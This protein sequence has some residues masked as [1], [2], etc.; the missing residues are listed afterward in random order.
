[1]GKIDLGA[2]FNKGW[3]AFS[4]NMVSMIVGTLIAVLITGVSAG[5]LATVMFGGLYGMARKS[6]RGETAEIGDVFAGF[7]NFGNLFLAGLLSGVVMVA[8]M[9]LCCVG[10][11]FTA[12]LILFMIPLVVDGNGVGEA[13]GKSWE[14]YKANFGGFFLASLVLSLV[15]GAGN[16]VFVGGLFTV[17][18]AICVTW[19]A[20]EQVFGA[21]E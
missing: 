20:Y 12:P 3:E 5:L 1:M 7:S 11:F 4:K 21:T 2:A 8:G 10:I 14:A 15:M 16:A 18:F 19:A 9:L 13:F 17:P 6:F